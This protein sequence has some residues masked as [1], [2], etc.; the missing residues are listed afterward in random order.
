MWLPLVSAA[1][2]N[3]ELESIRR[4]IE[5]LR[6]EYE[7]RIQELEQRLEQAESLA[8]EAGAEAERMSQQARFGSTE[9]APAGTLR[10]RVNA[11]N[12]AFSLILQ[13]SLNSYSEDP[14]SYRLPGF[15]V[16]GEAGLAP[17]GLTLDETELVAS[18]SVDQLFYAETTIAL[19]EDEEDG[20]E[21]D[22]EEAF[23]EPMLLPAG[24]GG[25][26]GRFYSD[27]GYLNR[28]HTHA[29]DFRDEPLVYRAFLGKQY[30]DDGVQ[31]N[32]T[33]PSDLYIN[34][35]AETLAG[36]EFPAGKSESV[37]G[38]VQSLFIDVGGDVGSSHAWQAG[39]SALKADVHDREGGHGHGDGDGGGSSF[40][41]DSDLY[42]ADLVWKWAPNGN[43]RERNFIFQTELFYRDEDGPVDFREDGNRARLDYDGEQKGLYAQG[44]YQFMPQWRIGARYDWL[45]A[46]NDLRITDLG[47]FTDPDEVIEESGFDDEGHNPERY[48]IMLDWSPSEFSRL[49]AQYNRDESR[50]DDTDHQWSLQYIM[51]L[52]AHGAHEF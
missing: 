11:F 33:A 27:I 8:R 6:N 18:A 29:W 3:A 9:P 32:W 52:G 36:K 40:S 23:F 30:R 26:A 38:D 10:E 16:G 17:E 22:V 44:I 48:S 45:D 14:E 12:P 37:F 47:G 24:L 39:L 49:R 41:G 46:D 34:V 51:S 31:L 43:P 50:P 5:E 15:Q 20:T 2:D 4:Q 28:I 25:R 42:I 7:S 21:V 19:H 1:A 35:G 13:G